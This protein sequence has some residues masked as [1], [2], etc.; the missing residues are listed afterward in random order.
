MAEPPSHGYV[1]SA[2]GPSHGLPDPPTRPLFV[3]GLGSNVGDRLW[4]LRRA[5]RELEWLA[6]VEIVGRSAV[7]ETAPVG[8]PPQRDF[9][10]AAVALRTGLAPSSLLEAALAIECRLGRRRPDPVHWGPRTI[11]IDLLWTTGEPVD[12]PGLRVPHA[13]LTERPFAVQPLLELVPDAADPAS[14]EPYAR[15]PAAEVSLPRVTML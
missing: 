13:R 15:L 4:S 5:V 9:L 2:M 8:G 10:N 3:L 6:Q 12:R 7:V 1:G 11:D 14:G